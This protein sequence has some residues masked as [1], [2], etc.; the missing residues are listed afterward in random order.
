M[1]V[2]QP[3]RTALVDYFCPRQFRDQRAQILADSKNKNFLIR[4]YLG[5]RDPDSR[6]KLSQ[7]R[8]YNLPLLVNDVETLGMQTERLIAIM[9]DALTNPHW[10]A[11]L[12]ANDVEYVLE[13]SPAMKSAPSAAEIRKMLVCE[14][15]GASP[16]LE[17]TKRYVHMWLLD[18]NECKE[19]ELDQDGLRLICDGFWRN[20]PYYPRP[21][22]DHANDVELWNLFRD[23][24]LVASEQLTNSDMPHEFIQKIE[25]DGEEGRRQRTAA[26]SGSMFAQIT[27]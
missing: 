13:S 22:S 6:K 14:S 10:K 2:P 15:E 26:G 8:F 21:G 12:D 27:S 23:R 3:C 7:V 17:F 1:P 20:D 5:R 19:F 24:Y 4:V 18:F 9:A 25:V 16:W 11:H